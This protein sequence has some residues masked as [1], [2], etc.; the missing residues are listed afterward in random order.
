MNLKKNSRIARHMTH[1]NYGSVTLKINI[2]DDR[3]HYVLTFELDGVPSL[4]C[5]ESSG[6]T[7]LR[8]S[9]AVMGLATT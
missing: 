7:M 4:A 8:I 2:I 3:V 9:S 6:C 5:T 1:C